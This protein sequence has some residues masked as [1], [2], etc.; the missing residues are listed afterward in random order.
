MQRLVIMAAVVSAVVAVCTTTTALADQIRGPFTHGKLN[1]FVL[2]PDVG[3]AHRNRDSVSIKTALAN[4][5]LRIF[6]TGRIDKLRVENNGDRPVLLHVGDLFT[7]GMQD[8]VVKGS[9]W[10]PPRSGRMTIDVLCVEA[11]R[12]APA[13]F[14]MQFKAAGVKMPNATQILAHG[15]HGVW[16]SVPRYQYL[17]AKALGKPVIDDHHR[18][19]LPRSLGKLSEAP[20]EVVEAF[21]GVTLEGATGYVVVKD[22]WVVAAEQFGSSDLLLQ[23][24]PK[25]IRSAAVASLLAPSGS[26][27]VASTTDVRAFL[28]D[29]IKAG[30][31]TDV[32]EPDGAL[33]HRVFELASTPLND[34]YGPAVRSMHQP[35]IR[36][37]PGLRH[38]AP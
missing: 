35:G 38:T 33:L 16:A 26:G 20:E 25:L 28:Q 4:G 9:V 19:S 13:S 22:G 21:S 24:W 3:I 6:E 27:S 17:L 10:I 5:A 31:V 18:S 8:R 37:M 12:W 14:D 36:F 34:H 32:V 30:R 15:Q 29:S 23:A 11:G 1:V 7:G 2:R